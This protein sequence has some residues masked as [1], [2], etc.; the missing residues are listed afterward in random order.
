MQSFG[1]ASAN[2]LFPS[3]LGGYF[4]FYRLQ[5]R[6]RGILPTRVRGICRLVFFFCLDLWALLVYALFCNEP[7]GSLVNVERTAVLNFW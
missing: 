2:F 1:D 4:T 6:V 7:L 3:S 5:A